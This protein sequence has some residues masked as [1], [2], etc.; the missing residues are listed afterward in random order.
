MSDKLKDLRAGDRARVEI[1][2]TID[3]FDDG[4]VLVATATGWLAAIPHTVLE[5]RTSRIVK[6]E[7]PLRVGDRVKYKDG[8]TAGVRTVKAIH[9]EFAWIVNDFGPRTELLS[10]LVRVEESQ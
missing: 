6:I 9:D 1:E 2:V 3:E 10:E 8:S 7:P 5:H 4:R